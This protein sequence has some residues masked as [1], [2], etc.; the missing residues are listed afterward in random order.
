MTPLDTAALYDEHVDFVWRMLLRLGVET[1]NVEDATQEV[2]LVAHRRRGEFK[3]A[4]SVRTWLT[5]IAVR[6]AKD[7]RRGARRS[8]QRVTRLASEPEPPSVD[9]HR[10]A[11]VAQAFALANSLLSQLDE[12][13]RAVF[14][15]TE[16]EGLRAVEI[17]EI[18]G[19]NVNTV[20]SRLRRAREH[21]NELVAAL[22]KKEALP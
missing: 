14:V 17:A 12:D 2:F 19:S 1:S 20:N 7:H 21:F 5:G 9:P 10:R 11:E 8:E 13:Q 16:W 4:S 6:V 22:K 18:I 3:H 15:L